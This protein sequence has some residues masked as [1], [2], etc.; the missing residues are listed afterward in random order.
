MIDRLNIEF[1]DTI[2]KKHSTVED[3]DDVQRTKGDSTVK[4]IT[5]VEVSGGE[6][7]CKWCV[8]VE[9]DDDLGKWVVV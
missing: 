3:L 8:V 6:I 5:Q 1:I 2:M 9:L 7:V 4:T